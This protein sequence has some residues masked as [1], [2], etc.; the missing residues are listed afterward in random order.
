M[1]D[2]EN[3]LDEE[4]ETNNLLTVPITIAEGGAVPLLPADRA[5]VSGPQVELI[6]QVPPSRADARVIFEWSTRPDFSTATQRDT[7][8]ARGVLARRMLTLSGPPPQTVY[9]RVRI[10]GDSVQSY[11]S[12]TYDPKQGTPSL[13]EGVAILSGTYPRQLDEGAP[14]SARVAFE[15][16]TEVPFRD[17]IRVLVR[18]FRGTSVAEK[19]FFIPPL[20]PKTTHSLTYLQGTLGQSGLNRVQIQFNS[21]RVPEEVYTNNTVEFVYTV[22]PDQSPPVLDVLVDGK[23]LRDEEVVSPQPTL[24]IQIL[25]ANP[26]LLRSDT[27]GL[28]VSIRKVCD[29]CAE[30][31][32]ALGQARWSPTPAANFQ[33]DLEPTAT[34]GKYLPFDGKSARPKR[35]RSRALPASASG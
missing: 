18:E 30:V 20:P 28:R 22:R 15:N 2:P 8:P 11:R 25:D 6:A 24:H 1:L 9:W 4:N 26:Y 21:N 29:Q 32:I 33:V 35:Q 27:T 19:S 7:V 16:L 5:V 23:R 31:P 34:H 13:P 12:F 14:F 3:T 17:S 10:V